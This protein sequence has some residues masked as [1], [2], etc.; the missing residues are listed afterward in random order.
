MPK[1]QVDLE[2]LTIAINDHETEWVL[3]VETGNVLMAEWVRDAEGVDDEELDPLEWGD[4]FVHVDPI[5]SREGFRWMERFALGVEN[6]TARERLLDALDRPRPFR[7]FKYALS[8]YPEIRDAWFRYEDERLKEAAR[9]WVESERLD[10]E[11]VEKPRPPAPQ[12]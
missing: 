5:P 9:S 7:R 3:D 8:D 12:P 11:L 1:I 4:R 6:D 2:D 10:V